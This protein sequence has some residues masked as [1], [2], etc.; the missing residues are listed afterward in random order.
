[1]KYFDLFFMITYFV[2]KK[3]GRDEDAAKWSAMLHTSMI[4]L[5]LII[6]TV[7]VFSCFYFFN[8]TTYIDK[9]LIQF[10]L[11][12]LFLV[13]VFYYRYFIIKSNITSELQYVKLREN[14]FKKSV[15]IYIVFNILVFVLFAVS[16]IINKNIHG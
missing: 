8:L 14:N 11:F 4:S 9:Y 12:D 5:L 10:L 6:I 2:L 3:L 7:S 1:M 16:A 15:A 13:V